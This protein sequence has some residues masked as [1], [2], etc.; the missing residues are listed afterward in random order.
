M[1]LLSGRANTR[2]SVCCFDLQRS[3]FGAAPTGGQERVWRAQRLGAKIHAIAPSVGGRDRTSQYLNPRKCPQIAGYSSETR[4]R[5]F[6]SDCV[7]ADAV[8][9]EP[10]SASNSLLTGKITG[11]IAVSWPRVAILVS[12]QRVNSVVYNEIPY[13]TEQGI[14][15]GLTGIF[16]KKGNAMLQACRLTWRTP[17]RRSRSCPSRRDNS[18]ILSSRAA[19]F[20]FCNLRGPDLSPP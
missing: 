3:E 11:N 12:N 19:N 9:I 4:K 8:G 20:E 5:R 17:S 18:G 2:C 6:A 16:A 13:A 7:V 1:P 15:E 10:I 14:F